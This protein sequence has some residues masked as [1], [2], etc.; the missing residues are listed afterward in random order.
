MSVAALTQFDQNDNKNEKLYPEFA[1]LRVDMYEE[2]IRFFEDMFRNNGSILDM[3]GA[4]HTFLNETL[5]K[6]YGIAVLMDRTGDGL[7]RFAVARGGMLGMASLLAVN[8][9]V[10]DKSHSA[11]QLGLRNA[12]RRTAPRPPANV[13][14]LPENIPEGLTARQ[15]SNNTVRRWDVPNVT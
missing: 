9:S 3:L 15:R 13:P 8:Q 4:N 14:Q 6:H 5:A 1:V 12:A 2:T 11:W 10:T 7:I